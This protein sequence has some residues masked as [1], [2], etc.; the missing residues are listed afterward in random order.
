MDAVEFLKPDLIIVDGAKDLIPDGDINNPKSCGETVQLLMAITKQYP[1]ALVTIL[2][3]N[4]NDSNL[5]GHIGTELVNKCSECWQV[6]KKE[7]IFEIEQAESRNE[8][9]EGFSF[10]LNADKLPVEVEALPKVSRAN[11]TD[12]KKRDAF[13]ECLPPDKSMKYA[14]L[15]AL[16]MEFYG[17]EKSSAKNHIAEGIKKKY[18]KKLSNGDYEF[19]YEIDPFELQEGYVFDFYQK[20]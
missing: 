14:E 13:K 4:K 18:L 3:E 15:A 19:I 10:E 8:P 2:H 11:A 6:V 16:Y 7:N 12:Q 17:C 20:E 1:V 9:I 5:R